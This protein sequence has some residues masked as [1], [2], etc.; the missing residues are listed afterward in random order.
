MAY[1]GAFKD[2][3]RLR[4]PKAALYVAP[5]CPAGHLPPRVGRWAVI[6]TSQR[7]VDTDSGIC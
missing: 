2:G 6:D 4:A 5:L 3:N 7:F 1:S